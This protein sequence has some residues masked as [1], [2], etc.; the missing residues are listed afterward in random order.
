[1]FIQLFPADFMSHSVHSTAWW[2]RGFQSH[3]FCSLAPTIIMCT[4]RA[5]TSL[6]SKKTSLWQRILGCN[7]SKIHL[8]SNVSIW[9][10]SLYQQSLHCKYTKPAA[11]IWDF[12]IFPYLG[13]FNKG[14]SL[15]DMVGAPCA[16]FQGK[17]TSLKPLQNLLSPPQPGL[18]SPKSFSS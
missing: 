13:P 4:V 1:M 9:Q 7:H 11:W 17:W 2:R 8:G 16:Q 12:T 10:I 6:R 3:L 18:S 14:F 5:A 15:K